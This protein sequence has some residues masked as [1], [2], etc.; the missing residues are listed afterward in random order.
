MKKST[1]LQFLS[2]ANR[3][4]KIGGMCLGLIACLMLSPFVLFARSDVQFMLEGERV[5]ARVVAPPTFVR[6]KFSSHYSYPVEYQDAKK[7]QRTGT[8]IIRDASLGTGDIISMRYLRSDPAR[9]RSE[10]GLQRSWPARVFALIAVL[11]LLAS[12]WNGLQ[13]VRDILRQ[14]RE[15]PIEAPT[16]QGRSFAE[17]S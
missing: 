13:G 14:M 15:K 8:A 16:V 11:V 10:Y 17:N 5:N 7:T 6:T 2:L 3:N 4:A 9:S 1:L 12:A